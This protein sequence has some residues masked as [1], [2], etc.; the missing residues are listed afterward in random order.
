M[1]LPI[2]KIQLLLIVLI[3]LFCKQRYKQSYMTPLLSRR[4]INNKKLT[5]FFC[6]LTQRTYNIKIIPKNKLHMLY[7]HA[8]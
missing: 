4:Y 7:G 5:S 3:Q 8:T 1:T 2:K 6:L